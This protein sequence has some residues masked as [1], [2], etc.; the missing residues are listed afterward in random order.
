MELRP[1]EY[2]VSIMMKQKGT[3][4]DPHD[5]LLVICGPGN[6]DGASEKP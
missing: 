2:V 3:R 4:R 6:D 5:K 1:N